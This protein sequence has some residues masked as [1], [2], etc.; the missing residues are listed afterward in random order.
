MGKLLN[1]KQNPCDSKCQWHGCNPNGKTYEQNRILSGNVCPFLYHS[2]YPYFLGL[3]Y[4]ADMENIWVCCPGENGVNALIHK[5][6]GSGVDIP[7]D[8]FVIYA[9]I[10]NDPICPHGHRK[11]ETITYPGLWMNDYMCPAGLNNIF[12]FLDLEIP[13]CINLDHLRCPDWKDNISYSI[14]K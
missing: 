5:R 14:K 10:I 8:K 9:E 11:G 13:S 3:L 12:P 4:H 2:L 7:P 6:Y 1:I